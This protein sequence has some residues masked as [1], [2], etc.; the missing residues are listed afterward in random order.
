[1]KSNFILLI[2][3]IKF[4]HSAQENLAIKTLQV[5]FRFRLL[6]RPPVSKY[7]QKEYMLLTYRDTLIKL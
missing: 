6:E 1:M 4:T 5:Y 3:W 7:G 2:S